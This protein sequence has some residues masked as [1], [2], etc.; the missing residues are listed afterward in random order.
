MVLRIAFPL[1]PLD[2]IY[3]NC[4]GC[5]GAAGKTGRAKS[6][7]RDI[8][9]PAFINLRTLGRCENGT[10]S[11][12]SQIQTLGRTPGVGTLPLAVVPNL[13]FLPRRQNR[14]QLGKL[15][16]TRL[17]AIIPLAH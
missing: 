5:G 4:R 17:G 11:V 1:T 14:P 10:H 7:T 15:P 8:N 13:G 2:S 6:V 9:K 16:P 3:T 12:F